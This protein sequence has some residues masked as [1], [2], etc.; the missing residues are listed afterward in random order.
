[1]VRMKT[2]FAQRVPRKLVEIFAVRR[3]TLRLDYLHEFFA[4][5][6]HGYEVVFADKTFL[7]LYRNRHRGSTDDK[8]ADREI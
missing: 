1:M 2:A 7:N 5:W 6:V 4:Q 3:N 8:T